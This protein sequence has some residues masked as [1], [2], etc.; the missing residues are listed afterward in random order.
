MDEFQS[1]ILEKNCIENQETSCLHPFHGIIN[2]APMGIKKSKTKFWFK[3]QKNLSVDTLVERPSGIF[4]ENNF[5]I[6]KSYH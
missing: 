1:I 5:N 3:R 4:G 2:G 6:E